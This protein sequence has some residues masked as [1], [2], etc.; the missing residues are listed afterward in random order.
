MAQA[1]SQ[2]WRYSSRA[3]ERSRFTAVP[4]S[5]RPPRSLHAGA[6]PSLH[7]PLKS[8]AASVRSFVTSARVEVQSK[9]GAGGKFTV[10]LPVAGTAS[11]E[12]AEP[13]RTPAP[14]LKR[15]RIL[16]IDDEA[17]V[18]RALARYLSE[19]EVVVETQAEN[20]L[21]RLRSGERFDAILT[22]M[23]MPQMSGI[24]FY[25]LVRCEWPELASSVM[26][27][28]GGVFG[29]E[30][31]DFVDKVKPIVY[32]KPLDVRLLLA[33]LSDLPASRGRKS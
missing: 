6:S 28:S 27:M 12:L 3:R 13:V 2:A 1:P 19:H 25:E 23:M 7:V 15:L 26:F 4:D 5:Y 14:G 30:A 17:P 29:A 10:K 21:R 31:Q 33:N 11:T 16:V 22:D 20:G 32:E 24:Q 18:G 8:A 9:K